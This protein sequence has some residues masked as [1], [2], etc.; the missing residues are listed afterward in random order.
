MHRRHAALLLIF[1]A[2]LAWVGGCDTTTSLRQLEATPRPPTEYHASLAEAYRIYAEQEL[3]KYDWW[4]SKYF[5]D[6]GLK[7]ANGADV[8]PEHPSDWPLG[9]ARPAFQRARKQ[10]VAQL[11]DQAKADQ[12]AL[13]AAAVFSY[14][15]W[16]ENQSEGWQDEEINGCRR[17]FY[18]ALN[19]LKEGPPTPPPL[20]PELKPEPETLIPPPPPASEPPPPVASSMLLYFPFDGAALDVTMLAQLSALIDSVKTHPDTQIVINGHADRA[21]TDAYNLEL[22]AKRAEFIQKSLLAA[23]VDPKRIQYFAFGETD[24]A[25]PTGD[26][27][28]EDANRRVEIFIE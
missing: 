27:T 4:S 23:G 5:A 21:G 17:G 24:P 16:I 15:C 19:R 8:A 11:S 2:P 3:A 26:N 10:L 20:Q 7:A 1:G 28:R 22:S 9:D 14:D 13:A 18:S 6:K 25:V 12:P